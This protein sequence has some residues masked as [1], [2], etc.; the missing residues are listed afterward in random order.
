LRKNENS[1]KYNLIGIY[2][3]PFIE[4]Y[5]IFKSFIKLFFYKFDLYFKNNQLNLYKFKKD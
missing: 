1:P 5:Y 2:V 4:S 3:R